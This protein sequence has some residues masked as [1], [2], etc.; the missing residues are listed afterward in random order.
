MILT[1]LQLWWR[2]CGCLQLQCIDVNKAVHAEN[3][4]V[5]YFIADS[6]FSLEQHTSEN[7]WKEQQ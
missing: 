1:H 3:L 5:T 6:E 2:N 7:L 4:N